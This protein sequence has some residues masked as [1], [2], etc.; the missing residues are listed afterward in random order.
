M[1]SNYDQFGISQYT[2][3]VFGVKLILS[4]TYSAVRFEINLDNVPQW[5]FNF[6]EIFSEKRDEG[7]VN[8]FVLKG[9]YVYSEEIKQKITTFISTN[10]KQVSSI[11]EIGKWI[12][13]MRLGE[14]FVFLPYTNDSDVK[15]IQDFLLAE[16]LPNYKENNQFVTCYIR[17]IS[18][19]YKI[20]VFD[21]RNGYIGESDKN[22]RCCLF[23]GARGLHQFKQKAHAISESLGNKHLVQNE[24][25]D[26]CNNFFGK[27]VEQDFANY[28]EFFRSMY[29]VHGKN[30][31]PKNSKFNH[32]D[33][34]FKIVVDQKQ[35]SSNDKFDIENFEVQSGKNVSPLN[36]YKSI[37]LYAVSLIGNAN[38]DSL[39]ETVRWLKGL[40]NQASLP[41]ISYSV[42]PGLWKD[43]PWAICYT[44]NNNDK[45]FPQFVIEFHFLFFVFVAI[46]PFASGDIKDFT[47]VDDYNFFWDNM[48]HYKNSKGWV[49]EDW[50]SDE[51]KE[52]KYLVKMV[53][54]NSL[55]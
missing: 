12:K 17:E 46:V 49:R 24:E 4:N 30:G 2:S 51:R 31:I 48:P 27:N 33:D 5:F 3:K 14:K 45:Q 10:N 44:R 37:V 7:G 32:E 11:N 19:N 23:C 55:Q 42:Q 26:S 34:V 50:S 1:S 43:S 53:R 16:N 40:N 52:L 47:N 29:R 36:L 15:K 41:L 22:K 28:M 8:T 38:R 6:I 18:C 25:C 39:I 20:Q 35:E 13:W 9:E 21:Q 54:N